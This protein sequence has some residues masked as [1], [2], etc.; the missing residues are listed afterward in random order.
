MLFLPQHPKKRA[1]A[2][3]LI[4]KV[5]S[6]EGATVVGWRDVPVHPDCL[7][8]MARSCMPYMQQ[9]FVQL[10]YVCGDA[11]ERKLYITR[12]CIEN[13]ANSQ[14]FTIEELY[15]VSCSSK[16][17][18]YKG[19]FVADQFEQFFPDLADPNFK[20]ALAL[21]HQ[22][23]S[24]NTFPSWPLAQPFRYMAHNGEI[25]TLRGNINKMIAREKTLSFTTVW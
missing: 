16:T 15:I 23:Y 12:K 25:N 7:G 18:T 19:M 10:R 6:S 2:I 9:V 24:T 11:L 4:S 20:S 22:R 14:N 13:E 21:I 5:A 3:S 17:M 1:T 8:D